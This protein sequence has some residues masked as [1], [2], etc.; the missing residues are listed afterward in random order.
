MSKRLI[1]VITLALSLAV[2]GP[3][4]M[5][6]VRAQE[7]QVRPPQQRGPEGGAP[8]P[9]R[10]QPGEQQRGDQGLQSDGQ[11]GRAPGHGFERARTVDIG[12]EVPDFTLKDL[13]GRDQSLSQHRGQVVVLEFV[14]ADDPFMTKHHVANTT[15]PDL[16]EDYR[17]SGVTWF[18]VASGAAADKDKLRSQ[19]GGWKID[20]PVLLDPDK[21]LAGVL[22]AR[23]TTQVFV[24]GKDGRLAYSGAIDDDKS[25]DEVGGTN[26]LKKAIDA[27]L[28]DEALETPKTD[29]YGTPI[30]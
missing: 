21:R 7:G 1:S 29:P 17:E 30:E 15:I 25:Q 10:R 3:S 24:V 2:L 26:F 19:V 27:V 4:T 23:T 14:A 13:D 16:V 12:Q 20:Y 9:E 5:T 8:G 6:L 11:E 28:A 22:G 18:A